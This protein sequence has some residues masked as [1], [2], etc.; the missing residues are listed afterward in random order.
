MRDRYTI[1]IDLIGLMIAG[2]ILALFV[3]FGFSIAKFLVSIGVAN[4]VVP[5]FLGMSVMIGLFV[6]W[7]I[8]AGADI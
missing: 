4:E 1:E 7:D 8:A 5:V 6:L 2:L 3:A